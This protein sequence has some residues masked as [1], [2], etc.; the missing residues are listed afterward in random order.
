MLDLS[1]LLRLALV[2]PVVLLLPGVAVLGLI[3]ASSP[4]ARPSG[5]VEAVWRVVIVSL[6]LTGWV[7]LVLAEFGVFRLITLLLIV[8]VVCVGAWLFRNLA[9]APAP[10]LPM[11]MPSIGQWITNP[12]GALTRPT[13]HDLVPLAIFLLA[14]TVFAGPHETIRGATAPASYLA[15]GAQVAR[16]GSLTLREPGLASLD[17]N[18][19]AL[20]LWEPPETP[21]IPIR[22][23][24]FYLIDRANGVSVPQ[25]FPLYPVWLAIFFSLGGIWAALWS[26][27]LWGALGV[28]GVYFAGRWAV[29]AWPAALGAVGLTLLAPQ[30]WF[31]RYP[32][33]ETFTQMLLW[34]GLAGATVYLNA[35]AAPRW[36]VLAGLALGG[37]VLTRIDTPFVLAIPAGMVAW[38]VWRRLGSHSLVSAVQA[39]LAEYVAFLLPVTLLTVHA[40]VHMLFLAR[41]Y[42]MS[43]ARALPVVLPLIYLAAVGGL[44]L[45]GVLV[46]YGRRG[47][48][49]RRALADEAGAAGRRQHEQMLRLAFAVGII[50]LGIYAY[51]IR[52]AFGQPLTWSNW[53]SGNV[54]ASPHLSLIQ[55]G[56]YLSPVGVALA[57]LG[58]AWAVYRAPGRWVWLTLT[59]GLFFAILYLY[60]PINNPRHIYV[61]RRYV[62]AVLPA[63]TLFG[64]YLL[65][66]IAGV[67][68]AS[69]GARWTFAR[70]ARLVVALTLVG[71]ALVDILPL[72]Q[73]VTA[74]RE[75]AGAVAQLD[76]LAAQ[77][78]PDAIL[79]FTD[80]NPM[81]EGAIFGVPLQF[82]YGRESYILQGPSAP[83]RLS[84]LL[85]RWQQTDRPVYV[86]TGDQALPDWP[87][88]G[89]QPIRL[90][91][92][93]MPSL[94][95]VF[96]H[97]PT[98]WF[99]QSIVVAV[100]RIGPPTQPMLSRVDI[101]EVDGQA[102]V[103]GVYHREIVDGI[104]Y[105]WTNGDATFRV[106]WRPDAKTLRLRLA[107]NSSLAVDVSLN[108]TPLGRVTAQP[109]FNEYRLPLPAGLTPGSLARIRLVSP[110]FVP[111]SSDTRQLGVQVDW[112]EMTS[113]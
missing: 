40:A 72:T 24:D 95:S 74:Q 80:T 56:W 15:V 92:L 39:T 105:R 27:P 36:G 57:I 77:L 106:P 89:F 93:H 5:L 48:F 47:G 8:V 20:F 102:V 94:E 91:R 4:T 108:E 9:L 52:P 17:P 104:S 65:A 50:A 7:A 11:D 30:V 41:P 64:G 85:N 101:G 12:S 76:A 6:V 98:T 45:L 23:P 61:V 58:A 69:L 111:S 88:L 75:E 83:E 37:V 79:V 68:P 63:F 38:G 73:A 53:Y 96:D 35:A 44:G 55:L 34:A 14:L 26:L 54:V 51:F 33:S 100:Y 49:K 112:L 90:A 70:L 13:R 62:P 97:P 71:V 109:G 2:I 1:S 84:G 19:A 113:E 16:T 110:T 81:G 82:I 32:A 60:N 67:G 28:L 59:V 22:F 78:E 66:W 42:L 31:S 87:D 43:T 21:G 99:N 25:V 10:P 18:D 3:P 46:W 103:N 86:F 107:A 29:G